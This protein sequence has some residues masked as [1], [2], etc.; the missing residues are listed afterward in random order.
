MDC[1]FDA[2]TE[3]EVRA[4]PLA[5]L[6]ERYRRYRLTSPEAE[7]EMVRSLRRWGQ[8]APITVWVRE[9]LAEVLDGFN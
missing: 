1:V 6:G 7:E 2:W 5:Q 4:M 8:L 3:G 9:G